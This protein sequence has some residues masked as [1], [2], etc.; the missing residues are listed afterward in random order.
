[1]NNKKYLKV[2]FGTKS[3]AS[4]LK[5]KIDEVNV[6]SIW[7]PSKKEPEEMGG[8]NFSNEENILRWLVRGDTLYDV[9]VPK[10]AEVVKVDN[11][12]A[13]NGVF[14]S[15]KIILTNPKKVTDELAME[16]YKKSKLPDKSYY[17]AIIGLAIRG[18]INTAT[19]ILKDKV[20]ENN[21]DLVISEVKEF[22]TPNPGHN[23]PFAPSDKE[24]T[25]KIKEYLNE[26]KSD[27]LIS[28]TINKPLYEK[29]LTDDN[30]INIT[31]E[32]GSGKSTYCQKYK[33][34]D[35]S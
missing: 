17:K 33:N 19:Q 30:I 18:H 10:D 20:N 22:T 27:L 7:D 32:S 26:I 13:P 21:I 25:D 1:M 9:E 35:T 11:P 23:G 34:N 3:G 4:D 28:L 2:M 31:G 5:Y 6:S 12:S 15:N 29:K 24:S 16:L 14:R 8:F